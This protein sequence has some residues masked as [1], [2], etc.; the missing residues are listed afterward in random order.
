MKRLLLL[1]CGIVS[2][3]IPAHSADGDEFSY[4]YKGQ[5]ITY[6]VTSETQQTCAVNSFNWISGALELPANAK[7]KGVSYSV[8]SIGDVA[9]Y[10][11][12]GL[13]SVTIPNSVTTIGDVALKHIRAH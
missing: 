3:A 1:L 10:D 11:C 8:T 7:Y 9:F 5:E 6:I 4:T 12:S 2:M 13:T